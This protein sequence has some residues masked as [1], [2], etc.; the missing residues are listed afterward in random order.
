MSKIKKY[1]KF[2]EVFNSLPKNIQKIIIK[3][4]DE[5]LTRF[6]CEL[7]IN[8]C[9]GNLSEESILNNKKINRRKKLIQAL[10]DRKKT[11]SRKVKYIRQSGGFIVPLL[12]S[13]AGPLI[14]KIISSF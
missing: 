13:I 12:I 4:I 1:R 14:S 9:N 2:I 3:N 5:D 8:I 11:L 6:L 10:A 7:C